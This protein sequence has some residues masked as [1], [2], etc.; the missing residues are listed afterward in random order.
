MHGEIGLVR[1]AAIEA[2]QHAA[3]AHEVDAVEDEILREL[4]W[5]A[6]EARDDCVADRAH[7]FLDRAPHLVGHE[8]D[9]LRQA[10]HEVAAA[11]LGLV[12]V[13]DRGGRPDREFDLLGGALPD[14]DAVLAPHVRLDRGVDVER[15]DAHR[16]ECDDATERD[17]RDLGGASA[18]VDDHVPHRL[19][20]REP[21]ADRGRHRLL[22]EERLRGARAARRLEHGTLLDVGDRRRHA[23]QHA[24]AVETVDAGA[25][26]EQADHAL[27][28][29]EVGDRA[30]A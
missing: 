3:A 2:A 13:G 26:E 17:D 1:D 14:R 27:R 10:R 7:L 22:D 20:D 16:F 24:C 18:D 8:H 5:R 4:R 12:L 23:D 19:V 6:R 15:A 21:G 25:L 28:D 29:L 9:R 30:T 11:H